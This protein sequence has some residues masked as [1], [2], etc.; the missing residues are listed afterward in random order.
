MTATAQQAGLTYAALK[1]NNWT[2]DQMRGAG[3]IV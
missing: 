1:G 3:Y 2:D